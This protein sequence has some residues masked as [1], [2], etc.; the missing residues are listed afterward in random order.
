MSANR[1]VCHILVEND[2]PAIAVFYSLQQ[3]IPNSFQLVCENSW[4]L[5]FWKSGV[6]WWMQLGH[7]LRDFG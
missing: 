5:S 7:W 2:L 6:K 3:I 4:L 1:N